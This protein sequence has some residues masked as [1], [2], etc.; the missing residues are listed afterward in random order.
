MAMQEHS[1]ICW[2]VTLA[3]R[4][5]SMDILRHIS[6][7]T[8]PDQEELKNWL[9]SL[10]EAARAYHQLEFACEDLV[11]LGASEERLEA[12]K[13]ALTHAQGQETYWARKDRW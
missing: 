8:A 6:T 7:G 9:R 12:M 5:L 4:D 1:K 13:Q 10:N 11:E 3:I 2:D